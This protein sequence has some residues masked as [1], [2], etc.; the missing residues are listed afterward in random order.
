[1]DT[2]P[3]EFHHNSSVTP[4][5]F[6][7]NLPITS[8]LILL[9]T[10]HTNRATNTNDNI[11]LKKTKKRIKKKT[12]KRD[13]GETGRQTKNSWPGVLMTAWRFFSCSWRILSLFLLDSASRTSICLWYSPAKNRRSR[14]SFSS[15]CRAF[16]SSVDIVVV[17][18]RYFNILIPQ[19][20]SR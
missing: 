4:I 18:S 9:T 1:M 16:W 3:I 15:F 6:N 10:K 20:I 19:C 11:P 7:H 14:F 8:V 2:P 5:Q 17:K 13:I 12:E